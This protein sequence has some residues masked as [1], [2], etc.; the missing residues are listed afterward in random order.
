MTTRFER[1]AEYENLCLAF[2][3]AAKGKQDRREILLFKK[4]LQQNL[5]QL[6]RDI[7]GNTLQCGQYRYFDVFEPKRRRICAAPFPD[8]ILHHAIMN[9]CEPVFERFAIYDSYA[10]RQ[11]KG[12][13]AAVR[14]AQVFSRKFTWF[15]KLDIKKYFD[16]IDHQILL[17][18]IGKRVK[19]KRVVTVFDSIVKSYSTV[20][21]KGMPIGNLISQHCANLY[22][23]ALDHWLKDEKGVKGYLR[24]MDD[25]VLFMNDKVQLKRLHQEIIQFLDSVLHLQLHQKQVLNRSTHAIPF[26]GMRVFPHSIKLSH[27]ARR[28]FLRK[29]RTFEQKHKD[30]VWSEE[31]LS[32]HVSALIGF[33]RLADCKG[34]RNKVFNRGI[35]VEVPTG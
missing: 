27:V 35:I 5:A 20:A 11:G 2:H 34:L 4:D 13:H 18:L 8:R 1:I 15:L 32:R 26:L 16:S 19:E 23:G 6:R 7:L 25:F 21:G 33:T 22:L 3:K 28:R 17:R 10:C 14:K 12:M 30:G 24:Y 29:I 9:V 31:E